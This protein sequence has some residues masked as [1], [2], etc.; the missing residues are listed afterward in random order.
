MEKDPYQ[1]GSPLEWQYCAKKTQNKEAQLI[2]MDQ[3]SVCPWCEN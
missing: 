3:Y 1:I 2:T